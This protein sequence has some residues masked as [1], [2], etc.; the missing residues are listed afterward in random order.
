MKCSTAQSL[1]KPHREGRGEVHSYS[2]G[3]LGF[4]HQNTAAEVTVNP[5]AQLSL[6]ICV[7]HEPANGSSPTLTPQAP[8]RSTGPS[9][10]AVYLALECS[11]RPCHQLC[12]ERQIPGTALQFWLTLLSF[13]SQLAAASAQRA[14]N[15][16]QPPLA[17]GVLTLVVQSFSHSRVAAA[18]PQPLCPA[19]LL[20][21]LPAKAL[22]ERK[23]HYRVAGQSPFS[24][25]QY[26]LP[27][28]HTQGLSSP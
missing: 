20:Q 18:Q 3:H 8:L 9:G 6:C 28:P 23:K 2:S 1:Q 15:L 24:S 10:R 22:G 12:R 21:H 11:G 4:P 13:C 27:S 25:F 19:L 7:L 17:S 5:Q 14:R 26:P 16:P